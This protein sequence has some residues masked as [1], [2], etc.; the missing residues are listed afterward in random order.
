MA[1]VAGHFSALGLAGIVEIMAL[2]LAGDGAVYRLDQ[3][4]VILGVVA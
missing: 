2:G 1:H 3:R 4:A